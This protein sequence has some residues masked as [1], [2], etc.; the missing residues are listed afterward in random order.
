VLKKLG[1]D[2]DNEEVTGLIPGKDGYT[3]GKAIVEI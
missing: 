1:F 3:V 2:K